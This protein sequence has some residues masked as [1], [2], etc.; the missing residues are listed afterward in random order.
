V[1]PQA[2]GRG[3]GKALT[4]AGIR[5]LQAQGLNAIMLYV[6][7]DNRAAVALYRKLGFTRWDV[8]VMY[9]AGPA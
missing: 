7:A 6:D 9:A 3:L 2:Q 1:T 8:D 4:I 5:H